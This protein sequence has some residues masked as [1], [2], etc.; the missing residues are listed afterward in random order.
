[1]ERGPMFTKDVVQITRIST[2]DA[3]INA[4]KEDIFNSKWQPGTQ[5]TEQ[6]LTERYGVSRHSI[7]EALILLVNNGYLE[8]RVNKGVFTRTFSDHDIVDIYKARM[9]I[10]GAAVEELAKKKAVPDEVINAMMVFK[11]HH[12]GDPWAD[13]IRS[14]MQLHTSLVDSLNNKR[15]SDTFNSL[16]LE[17]QLINKQPIRNDR[18]G[19]NVYASHVRIVEEIKNGDA[20]KAKN[21]MLDHLESAMNIQLDEWGLQTE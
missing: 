1:M 9:L 15:I 14:D 18:E 3:L 21:S 7:R 20:E 19:K 5:I 17:I 2:I 8:K 4:I 13:I 11:E 10:E 6:E 12:S 16:M